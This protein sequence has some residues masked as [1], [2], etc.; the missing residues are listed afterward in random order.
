M[1]SPTTEPAVPVAVVAFHLRPLAEQ[2]ELMRQAMEA[3]RQRAFVPP[4][5][6]PLVDYGEERTWQCDACHDLRVVDTGTR[7]VPCPKCGVEHY[8]ERLQDICGLTKQQ[9]RWTF[10]SF[11]P[12]G[13]SGKA[14]LKAARVAAANPR[15]FLTLTGS[16]GGGK[17]HLLA[18][19]VNDCRARG[20]VSVYRTVARLLDDLRATFDQGSGDAFAARFDHFASAKVLALDEIEKFKASEWAEEQLFKLI[21]E[22]YAHMEE[23]LT[24]ISTNRPVR[25]GENI[26]ANTRYPGYLE[27]RLLDGRFVVAELA[28]GDVRPHMRW[29]GTRE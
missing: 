3:K 1:A 18:A 25:A 9:Q 6:T 26:I 24:V 19:I 13:A 23:C 7:I 4:E 10:F 12:L 15:G 20:L 22:R 8:R 29:D 5:T 16:W 17:S 11:K 14:A 2:V 27:S 21:D 28:D